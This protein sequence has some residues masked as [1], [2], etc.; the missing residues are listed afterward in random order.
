M[1]KYSCPVGIHSEDWRV[2]SEARFPESSPLHF[3][4]DPPPLPVGIQTQ[5]RCCLPSAE[6]YCLSH[7]YLRDHLSASRKAN[8]ELSAD[9]HQ[10]LPASLL[11]GWWGST[12][13]LKV[14]PSHCSSVTTQPTARQVSRPR[15]AAP[16]TL[17]NED[18]GAQRSL[19]NGVSPVVSRDWTCC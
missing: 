9:S 14:G 19:L 8:L 3:T 1:L 7:P 4:R 13:V 2:R 11:R 6:L 5:L 10:Q 18:R 15:S 17:R 12:T 16:R